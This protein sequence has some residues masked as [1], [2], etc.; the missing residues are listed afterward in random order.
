MHGLS[1]IVRINNRTPED[2]ERFR[3]NRRE[4]MRKY[5]QS[6]TKEQLRKELGDERICTDDSRQ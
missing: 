3:Q 4:H 2:E 6:Y 5:P 1:D